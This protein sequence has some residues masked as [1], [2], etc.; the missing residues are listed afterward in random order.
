MTEDSVPKK[1]LN[2][3]AVDCISPT[4]GLSLY[5]HVWANM[6]ETGCMVYSDGGKTCIKIHFNQWN[7]HNIYLSWNVNAGIL[8]QYCLIMLQAEE[9]NDK[10]KG[11][12]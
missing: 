7:L 2:A 1:S 6:S 3:R 12:L 10:K 4:F 5:G 9:E 8:F 11:I